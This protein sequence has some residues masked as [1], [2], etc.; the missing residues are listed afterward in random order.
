MLCNIVI[1]IFWSHP[2]ETI[3]QI[4]FVSNTHSYI[5]YLLHFIL[6][7]FIGCTEVHSSC[8]RVALYLFDYI[9]FILKKLRR[10]PLLSAIFPSEKDYLSAMSFWTFLSYMRHSL[11]ISMTNL[12]LLNC[13]VPRYVVN[14]ERGAWFLDFWC[15]TSYKKL[16]MAPKVN[17]ELIRNLDPRLNI[18]KKI[19]WLQ[20]NLT[21][22]TCLFLGLLLSLDLPRG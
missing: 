5:L 10:S 16:D 12:R 11:G 17:L 1:L 15:I 18:A 20:V 8:Q 21:F 9:N 6:G 7:N 13:P 3:L 14:P 22:M 2:S 4:Q 19:S